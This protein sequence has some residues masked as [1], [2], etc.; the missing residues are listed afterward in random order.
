MSN[1]G[2]T[3]EDNMRKLEDMVAQLERSE[4]PLEQA[5]GAFEQGM[6]LVKVCQ[7][8]LDELSLRVEKVVAAHAD[9]SVETEPFSLES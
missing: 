2:V 3:F 9:G 8:Q 7:K 5:L 4:L 6:Q 1:K